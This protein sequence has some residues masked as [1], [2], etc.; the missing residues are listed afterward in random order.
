MANTLIEPSRDVKDTVQVQVVELHIQGDQ[1]D[2][3]TDRELLLYIARNAITPAN[4]TASIPALTAVVLD[5]LPELIEQ[6]ESYE[7]EMP[8]ILKTAL[9]VAPG[10]IEQMRR[11]REH[12]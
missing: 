5:A 9:R 6:L 7:A 3:M 12:T 8:L 11:R 2:D 4:I 1:Y 10:F